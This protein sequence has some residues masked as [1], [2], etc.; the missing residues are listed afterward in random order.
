M[1]IMKE[2]GISSK[3]PLSHRVEIDKNRIETANS[4]D[5]SLI[6]KMNI[7]QSKNLVEMFKKQ[8]AD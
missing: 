5:D 2:K 6:R 4:S 3:A 8:Y 1:R 7:S